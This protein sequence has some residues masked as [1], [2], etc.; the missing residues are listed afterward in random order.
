MINA[1]PF[2]IFLVIIAGTLSPFQAG[3]NAELNRHLGHP[4]IAAAFNCI[5]A[6][7]YLLIIAVLLR[8]P[9]PSYQAILN[10]PWW[11]W[12]GGLC[13][14]AYVTFTLISAPKLGAL[15]LMISFIFGTISMSIIIDHFGWVGYQVKSLTLYRAIGLVALCISIYCIY[16][17]R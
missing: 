6:G 9:T 16:K 1:L 13:G 8:V 14:A 2:L 3:I 17:G 10:T 7:I 4:L 5:S 11:A 15:L 12:L